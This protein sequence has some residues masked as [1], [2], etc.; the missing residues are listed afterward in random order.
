MKIIIYLLTIIFLYVIIII[1]QILQIKLWEGGKLD[2]MKTLNKLLPQLREISSS[3]KFGEI[4]IKIAD[5]KVTY[6]EI[7]RKI[8]TV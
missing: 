2:P 8:K 3:L 7:K 4:V 5:G 1:T 6:V